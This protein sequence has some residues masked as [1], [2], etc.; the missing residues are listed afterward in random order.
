M[1]L[2]FLTT[3]SAN[4]LR[5]VPILLT[6]V[7]VSALLGVALCLVSIKLSQHAV[8]EEIRKTERAV[9]R[10]RSENEVLLATVTRLSSRQNL[11]ELVA[12]S[13]I[14]AN[15]ITADRVAR[16]TPP[17]ADEGG[18]AARTALNAVPSRSATR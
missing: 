16:L 11:T 7:V 6:A 2:P 15:Y 12:K 13:K 5:L 4:R 10:I 8:A 18:L 9:A 1:K 17:V 14:A 3:G